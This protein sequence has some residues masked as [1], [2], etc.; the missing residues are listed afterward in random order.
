MKHI[1]LAAA[2]GLALCAVL[3]ASPVSAQDRV[4]A[5]GMPTTHSTPA[6]QAQ[7]ANLNDQISNNN[8]QA[9]AQAN[10]NNAQYQAQ[11]D[12]YQQRQQ[13]Y[14]GKLAAN[15]A[16][17]DQF[18]A[19]SVAYE[20]LRARYAAERAAYHRHVWPGHYAEWRPR[21]SDQLLGS[22]VNLYNGVQVGEVSAVAHDRRGDVEAVR[23]RMNDYPQ[24]VWLDAN[25][26]R[27]SPNDQV[28]MTDLDHDELRQM[29][30]QHL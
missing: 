9:D 3:T 15:Q 17:Q 18:A 26:V 8:A 21:P 14:Q 2:S 10:A 16:A 13:D 4:D 19:D 30:D 5:N 25:D 22:R 28:V 20:S 6:E 11:Q 29:A 27:F 7:T 12:Q 1:V 24:E 23:V